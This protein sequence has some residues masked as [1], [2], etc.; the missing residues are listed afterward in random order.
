MDCGQTIA[1]QTVG[2]V[3]DVGHREDGCVESVVEG[4]QRICLDSVLYLGRS[5]CSW[6]L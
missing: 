4:W 2:V 6:N 1:R 3:L 5:D